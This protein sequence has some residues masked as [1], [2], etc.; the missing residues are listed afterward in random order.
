[1][2]FA[3]TDLCDDYAAMLDDGTLAVLRV[4]P[5]PALTAL[6]RDFMEDAVTSAPPPPAA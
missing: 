4:A 6:L 5:H 3:T 2:T 1:M